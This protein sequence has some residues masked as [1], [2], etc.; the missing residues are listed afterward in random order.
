MRSPLLR[1]S[2]SKRKIHIQVGLT[3]LELMVVLF[4]LGLLLSVVVGTLPTNDKKQLEIQTSHL[5]DTLSR[6][7]NDAR[8]EGRFYGLAISS[9]DWQFVD[10]KPKSANEANDDLNDSDAQMILDTFKWQALKRNRVLTDGVL[11][12]GYSL[13]LRLGEIEN[14]ALPN[15]VQLSEQLD[16]S[17][18]KPQIW[19]LPGGEVTPFILDYLDTQNQLVM[20]LIV[21]S[22]GSIELQ[23]EDFR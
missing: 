7:M 2:L 8:L 15:E 23:T 17:M 3:L 14:N 21:D 20:R 1:S 12:D 18:L 19:V 16:S 22:Q 5:S 13:S 9:Q 11:P 4:L 10:L 6:L